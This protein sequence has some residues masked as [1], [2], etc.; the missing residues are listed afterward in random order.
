MAI[1]FLQQETPG[2]AESDAERHARIQ[3]EAALIAKA[4]ADIDA[5]LGIADGDLEQWL[6]AL[7]RDSTTPKPGPRRSDRPTR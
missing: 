2:S 3:R 5:G 7:D 1:E 6:D 4:E